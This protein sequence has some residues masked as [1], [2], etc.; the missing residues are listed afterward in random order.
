[1]SDPAENVDAFTE[2][3][4]DGFVT[5]EYEPIGG[6]E[7]RIAA[8]ADGEVLESGKYSTKIFG[9]VTLRGQFLNSVEESIADKTG[10]D[11]EKV[12][13]ELKKWFAE[14]NEADREEQADKFLTDE[15][16][17]IIQ[18]THYPVE[19]HGGET[20][21]WK[22]EMTYAGRNAVLEFNHKEITGNSAKLLEEK[23]A[24]R[25]FEVIDI[26]EEDWEAIKERWLENTEVVTVVE[27]KAKDAIADRVLEKL[28]NSVKPVGDRENMGNDVAAAWYDPE[29][30]TVYDDAPPDA[31]IVWVQD[32]FLVDQLEAA[33]K[34]VKYKFQL[35]QDLIARGD[36]YGGRAR[37]K[38]AWDSR[39]TLYPFDP[40]ALGITPDA[41]GEPDDPNH[42]EVEA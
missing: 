4:A 42:S 3:I 23:I 12:R 37:K 26:E 8:Y 7:M 5:L 19:I 38:W 31:P 14:M 36:L 16:R 11:A 13:N 20:S 18:G 41:V 28:G 6:G 29:N 24:N 9:S 15:I 32:S 39:T 22:V 2:E 17:A 35:I 30:K 21:T 34:D 27:G 1:M 25:F 10:V 40:E 33:G